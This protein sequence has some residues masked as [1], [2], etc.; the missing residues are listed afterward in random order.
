MNVDETEDG[1][2][3]WTIV[4]AEHNHQPP[5]KPCVD[6]DIRKEAKIKLLADASPRRNN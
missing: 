6:P 4:N 3:V 2:K 5:E 1:G